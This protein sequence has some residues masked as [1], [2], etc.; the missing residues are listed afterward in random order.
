ML[1]EIVRTIEAKQSFLIT[2]H[3]RLDGDAI[4]SEV[5]LYRLLTRLGKRVAIFNEDE[6]PENF[7]FLMDN[8]EIYHNIPQISDYNVLFVIDCSDLERVGKNASALKKI[9]TIINIDHHLSNGRFAT[10]SYLDPE[11]SSTGELIFRL[12]KEMGIP[13]RKEEAEGLYTAILTDTGGF[14]YRNTSKD[15]LLV[16][17]ALVDSG[18][19]PQWLSENIYENNAVVKVLL[20][21]KALETLNLA[22]DG[23]VAYVTVSKDTM[24]ALGAKTQH[25]DGLVDIVRTIKGVQVAVLFLELDRNFYKLSFRSKGGVDVEKVARELGGG[26]HL[27]AAACEVKGEIAWIRD[28]VFSSLKEIL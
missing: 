2:S 15:T 21:A 24:E 22:L 11:A 26:G 4:G 12:I 10:V 27:N 14:R 1:R 19:D 18:A 25:I 17:A 8:V 9:E 28:R 16:A 23:K 20:H 13:L 6:I 7:L 5:A 3:V